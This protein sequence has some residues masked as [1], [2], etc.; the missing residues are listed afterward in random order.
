MCDVL[1]DGLATLCTDGY[2]AAIPTLRQALA[3]FRADDIRPAQR[4][5]FWLASVVAA[6]L[7]DDEGWHQLATRSLSFAREAG[8]LS[9]LPPALGSRAFVDIFAG[10]LTTAAS[11]V[12]ESQAVR[13]IIGSYPAPYGSLGLMAWSG[14]ESAT[15]LIEA[16]TTEVIS[17]GDGIGVTTVRWAKALLCNG[18]GRYSDALV[19]AQQAARHPEEL[20]AANWGLV[21]LIEAAARSGRADLA[22]TAL[23]TLSEMTSPSGTNWGLG[24]EARCRALLAKAGRA[25]G[26]YREAIE[27][28]DQTRMQAEL[29]RAH[30]VYG[31]WLRRENRRRDARE[32]LREA[33]E[34]LTAMGIN[35]FA[36]R[37]RR[38]LLATGET[39]RARTVDTFDELTAQEAQIARL[40]RDGR[41]NP[42][43]GAELFIS[44]RT[45]EW[46]LRKVYP[47]L[48]ISTR[49]D[50]RD[51]LADA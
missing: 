40:A 23:A 24:I 7:W 3:A 29:A 12:S 31:E 41:T 5:S 6:D 28:L 18:L 32:Q 13:E 25:E 4:H 30:L 11:L 14:D 10:D 39:V 19:A 26:L 36:E 45:V 9:E 20:V 43:I 49:K 17:R 33:H 44:P 42:E 2:D 48:G 22:A 1:L 51:A 16:K 50:L 21:E 47:K 37:A 46:H 34:M 15:A 38:E 35:A 8:E 27:R